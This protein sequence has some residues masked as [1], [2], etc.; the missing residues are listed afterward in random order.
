MSENKVSV[1]A[2]LHGEGG[3]EV[4]LQAFIFF[5]LQSLHKLIT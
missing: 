1:T 5:L 4:H 2:F 3:G